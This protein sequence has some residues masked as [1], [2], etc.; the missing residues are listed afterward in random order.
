MVGDDVPILRSVALG[1]TGKDSGDRLPRIGDGVL[2]GAETEI[3]GIT[4]AMLGV[5]W[6]CLRRFQ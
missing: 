6:G 2:I 3:L 5:G 4:R 1:G